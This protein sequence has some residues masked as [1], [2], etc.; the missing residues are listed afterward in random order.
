MRAMFV[1]LTALSVLTSISRT[2]ED[3][4][5]IMWKVHNRPSWDDMRSKVI[6]TLYGKEGRLERTKAFM[7]YSKRDPETGEVKMLMRMLEPKDAASISLLIHEHK[8][9][10]DDMWI[11]IPALRKVKRIA[12]SGKAGSFMGTD[13]SNYDI[14]GGELEDWNYKLIGEEKVNGQDCWKIEASPKSR[15]VVR[16]SGY[17][18]VIKWVRKDNYLVVRSDHYDKSGSF[19]KRITVPKVEKIKGVWFETEMVAENLSSGHRSV[20]QFKDIEVNT[21]LKDSLF[22]KRALLRR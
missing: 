7:S 21:G 5:Q 13:F 17:S 10:E 3:A 20:F 4:Y 11:Y 16:K 18:R 8:N 19:F 14:G 6:V 1:I 2:A 15:K 9:R 22:I 12:A